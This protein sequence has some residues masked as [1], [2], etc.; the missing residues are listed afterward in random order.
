MLKDCSVAAGE[1]FW[2]SGLT[3]VLPVYSVRPARSTSTPMPSP[4]G[5]YSRPILV[6]PVESV[7]VGWLICPFGR[8]VSGVA[9]DGLEPSE[10]TASQPPAVSANVVV[11]VTTLPCTSYVLIER[12]IV[13]FTGAS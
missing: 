10:T 5:S 6:A 11:S 13:V 9:A 1:P 3:V 2:L 8:N 12:G 7:Y 4:S